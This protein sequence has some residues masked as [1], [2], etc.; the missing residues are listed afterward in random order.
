MSKASVTRL[1]VGSVLAV[2]AGLILGGLAVWYAF[3]NDAFVMNGPDV[4][5]IRGTTFAWV[6]VGLIVVAGLVIIAGCI[7][8]VVSWIGALLATARIGETGWFLILLL[9]GLW[10]LG[11]LAMIVYVLAGPDEARRRDAAGEF[12]PATRPR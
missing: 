1:F 2:V 4:T 9:L 5:G 12:A 8:G 10:N 3:A 7:G 11:L 6:M